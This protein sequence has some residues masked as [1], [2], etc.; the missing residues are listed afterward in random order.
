MLVIPENF[1]CFSLFRI[2][3]MRQR[4]LEQ[5]SFFSLV[6]ELVLQALD[7]LVRIS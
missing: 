5:I 7:C 2:S 1:V 6:S 4:F 3:Y